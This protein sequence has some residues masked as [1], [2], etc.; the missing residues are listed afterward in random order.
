MKI[1]IFGYG[2][3]GRMI[4]QAALEMGHTVLGHIDVDNTADAETMPAADAVLDFS[5]PGLLPCTAAYIRR[6]GAALVSG[7]TGYTDADMAVLKELAACAPVIYSA[8]YSLG[9]ALFRHMLEELPRDLLD[10][11]DIEITETHHRQKKDAPSG[12]AKLLLNAIDPNHEK[13]VV[14]GREGI[15]GARTDNE[16]GVLSLRGGTVAGEHTVY[17]FG[18]DETISIKHS[19]A[20]RRIFV[21]GALQ[22]AEKLI[23][24]PAGWYSLD[25][26]LFG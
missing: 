13:K 9:V 16:I 20:S 14:S 4:E 12:T 8:N 22:T 26:L 11:F 7:T 2:K 15:V 18:E 5:G 3:M 23:G 19:A 24:R 10:R 21:N 1:V 6:T 17:L 25:E